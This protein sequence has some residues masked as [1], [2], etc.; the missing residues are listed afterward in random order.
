MERHPRRFDPGFAVI[1]ALVIAVSMWLL[2]TPL[3]PPVSMTTMKRFHLG[4]RSFALWAAQFPIPAMYNF[5]NR[6]E[7]RYLP[8]GLVDP[9]VPPERS[10]YLNHFPARVLT[11]ADGRFDLLR[12]RR[13]C[14]VTVTSTYRA[15]SLRT[16]FH[17]EAA[18]ETVVLRRIGVKEVGP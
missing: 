11:F 16:D 13:D 15:R 4:S 7:V 3:L 5:A 1:A 9:L 6:C 14:W 8:P 2:L 17:A 10:A 12:G 18:G